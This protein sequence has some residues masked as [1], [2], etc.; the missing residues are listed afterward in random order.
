MPEPVNIIVDGKGYA[1][2]STF[3]TKVKVRRKSKPSVIE[4]TSDNYIY[5]DIVVKKKSNNVIWGN[6][7]LGGVIG[8]GVIHL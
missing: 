8:V 4:V 7:V 5:Q 1:N 3:P 2:V 6:L